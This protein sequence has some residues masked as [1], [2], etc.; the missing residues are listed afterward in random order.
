MTVVSIMGFSM[1]FCTGISVLLKNWEAVPPARTA[2]VRL[3][4]SGLMLSN[5]L[6]RNETAVILLKGNTESLGPRVTSLPDQP[7]AFQESAAG[8]FYLPPVPFGDDTPW[9]LRSLTID[10]K[11]SAEIFQKSFNQGFFQF[12]IYAGSLIF[13]LCSLGYAIKFSAWPLVNLFLGILVF[14]GILSL[15]TF[16]NTPEMLEII[17]SFLKGMMPVS[18]AVPLIFLILGTLIHIYSVL[19]S[20]VKRQAD[21]DF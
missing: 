18:L 20:F 3:G 5:S 12:L 6:N 2:A 13:L 4:G 1:L 10:I 16:L 9:F 11:L 14:R 7:L 19:V 15:Q 8:N 17:D 21:D